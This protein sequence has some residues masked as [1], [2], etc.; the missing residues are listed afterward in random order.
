MSKISKGIILTV[1]IIAALLLG[2]ALASVCATSIPFLAKTAE[3][4]FSPTTFK[5]VGN[6]LTLGLEF[7]INVSQVLFLG[8]AVWFYPK[9]LKAFSA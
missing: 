6:S 2:K 4:G 7:S 5:L 9:A 1:L 3:F 8:I